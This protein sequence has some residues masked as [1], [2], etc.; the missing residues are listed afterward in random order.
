METQRRVVCRKISQQKFA[1]PP[2]VC[3]SFPETGSVK[4]KE[5]R[6]RANI[7]PMQLDEAILARVEED[8]TTSTRRISAME[9]TSKNTVW[10][11]LKEQSLHPFHYQQVQ[12][13]TEGDSEN[14]E[15]FCSCQLSKT[16]FSQRLG[17]SY[18]RSITR[19]QFSSKQANRRCIPSILT[20]RIG[21]NIR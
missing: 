21:S 20:K 10:R 14:R 8:P 11:S 16:L 5:T 3:N 9:N 18:R 19:T 2:N 1:A 13:L 6:D 15:V 4:L 7:R 17:W 12:A